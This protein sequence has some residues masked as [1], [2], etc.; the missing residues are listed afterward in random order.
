[1]SAKLTWEKTLVGVVS[2]IVDGT[3]YSVRLNANSSLDKYVCIR[4]RRGKP[5]KVVGTCPTIVDGQMICEKHYELSHTTSGEKD[6]SQ[7]N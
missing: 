2:N 3:Q 1:M 6:G 4:E 5:S 7:R